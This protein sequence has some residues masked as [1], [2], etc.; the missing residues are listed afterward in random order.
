M[1]FSSSPQAALRAS[2]E[3]NAPLWTEAV[4]EGRI[5]SRKAATDAA[6]VEAI[7]DGLPMG[8]R[9]LDVGCGEGWLGRAL[10]QLGVHVHGIDGSAALIQAAQAHGHGSFDLIDYELAAED[11]SRLGGPYDVAVFNFALLDDD[12]VS[13]LRAARSSLDIGG[14]V[15]IQTTHPL[16]PDGPYTDGWRRE[17]FTE[18]DGG[19]TP[20]PWYFRTLSSWIRAIRSAGLSVT[21]LR[22]PTD[23]GTSEPLSLLFTTE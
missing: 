7:L 14:R 5:P 9:V 22:E 11:P 1:P 15:L 13:I 16:T 2:W 18:L 19:F 4:R 17:L 23:I 10:H 12:A 8:G 6:I 3:T 20:M 21:D